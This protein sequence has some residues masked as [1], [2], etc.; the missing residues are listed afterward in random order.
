L[1]SASN[2]QINLTIIKDYSH[3]TGL[4]FEPAFK[5]INLTDKVLTWQLYNNQDATFTPVGGTPTP[6]LAQ[7]FG[8]Y[9]ASGGIGA[10]QTTPI[11]AYVNNTKPPGSYQGS[12]TLQAIINSQTFN[13]A[14]ITYQLIVKEPP[15]PSPTLVP[16]P[17]DTVTP[18]PIP[19]TT[20]TP[21]SPPPTLPPLG[22][23]DPRII[24]L[25]TDCSPDFPKNHNIDPCEAALYIN[26]YYCSFDPTNYTCDPRIPHSTVPGQ[27]SADGAI[28]GVPDGVLDAGELALVINNV[29]CNPSTP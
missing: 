22:N 15:S 17:T 10:Y 11:D 3:P 26:N 24:N 20:G 9:Q 6:I 28:D 5:V 27:P 14:I 21:T 8:F 29:M 1:L 18:S 19:T 13:Q 25:D 4:T 7:G 16:T 23:C 2:Y 12:Y